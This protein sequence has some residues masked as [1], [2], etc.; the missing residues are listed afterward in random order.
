MV[1]RVGGVLDEVWRNARGCKM[2]IKLQARI[3]GA[4]VLLFAL[5]CK[6]LYI[7]NYNDAR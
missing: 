7:L 1:D 2:K 5:A 3:A 6:L 4:R